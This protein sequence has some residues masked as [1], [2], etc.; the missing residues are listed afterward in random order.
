MPESGRLSDRANALIDLAE[1]LVGQSV[2]TQLAELRERLSQPLNVVVTGTVSAGKSTLVNALLGRAI[3]PTAGTE[4]TEVVARIRAGA[5]DEAEMVLRGSGERR[6]LAL[7]DSGM[8]PDKLPIPAAEVAELDVSVRGADALLD[9]ITLVD[10]PGFGGLADHERRSADTARE[11]ERA[12]ALILVVAGK[13]L[14][15]ELDTVWEFQRSD[16]GVNSAANTIGVRTQADLIRPAPGEDVWHAAERAA[17]DL[18]RGYGGAVATVLPLAGLVAQ[19][20]SCD[21]LEDHTVEDLRVLAQGDPEEL[22]RALMATEWFLDPQRELGV[23]H[24][25]RTELNRL[26]H[27]KGIEL[28]VT[29]LREADEPISAGGL[30]ERLRVRSGFTELERA[31]GDI[32]SRAEAIKTRAVI[33]ELKKLSVGP[34]TGVPKEKLSALRHAVEQMEVSDPTLHDL[35]IVETLAAIDAGR[36]RLP[37]TLDSEA[38]RFARGGSVTERLCL[39]STAAT[40]ARAAIERSSRRWSRFAAASGGALPTHLRDE[41]ARLMTTACSLMALELP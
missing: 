23:S 24:E 15:R 26:L 12:G 32:A 37:E 5:R 40:E 14:E 33:N 18:R 35:R 36:V 19:T 16:P 39:A 13:E 29:L 10:T 25:A 28:A 20:V 41:L 11:M 21:A 30:R 9:E 22:R 2:P 31:V 3:A 34:L 27:R 6:K 38:R 7:A 8:H 17:R 1:G 4:N